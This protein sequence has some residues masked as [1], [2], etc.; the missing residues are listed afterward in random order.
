MSTSRPSAVWKVAAIQSHLK[1]PARRGPAFE[2][3]SQPETAAPGGHALDDPVLEDSPETPLA[4]RINRA[5]EFRAAAA[6]HFGRGMGERQLSASTAGSSTG[7][8]DA[9]QPQ[10]AVSGAAAGESA[11]VASLDSEHSARLVQAPEQAQAGWPPPP[12]GGA[13]VYVDGWGGV[14]SAPTVRQQRSRSAP[15]PKHSGEQSHAPGLASERA[16]A[17]PTTSERHWA[18]TSMASSDQGSIVRGQ[19]SRPRV[20]P[21]WYAANQSPER[22]DAAVAA[23]GACVPLEQ[24][25]PCG[26][27]PSGAGRQPQPRGPMAAAM[28]RYVEAVVA[29]QVPIPRATGE[30]RLTML[31]PTDWNRHTACI[32]DIAAVIMMFDVEATKNRKNVAPHMHPVRSV[33]LGLLA[34]YGNPVGARVHFHYE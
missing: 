8:G 24:A 5:I 15:V 1:T 26:V 11:A 29:Q 3:T 21:D 6:A 28:R 4:V 17:Q 10:G 2:F 23:S 16:H 14:S 30:P 18:A 19:A 34:G 20:V 22:P 33:A 25:R 12:A 32:E 7:E 27:R 31:A 13:G 9:P